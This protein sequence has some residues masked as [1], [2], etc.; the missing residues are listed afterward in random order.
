MCNQVSE[1]K[2]SFDDVFTQCEEEKSKIQSLT[3]Q[4]D[5][6]IALLIN[7]FERKEILAKEIEFRIVHLEQENQVLGESLKRT[8]G[9]SNEE[10]WSHIFTNK[11]AQQAHRLGAATWQLF[12]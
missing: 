9:S 4:R 10:C 5:E 12:Q 3:V 7:S 11:A 1:F 8:S 6:E 2:S